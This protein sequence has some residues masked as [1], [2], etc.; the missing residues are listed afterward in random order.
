MRRVDFVALALVIALSALLLAWTWVLSPAKMPP[1]PERHAYW[2]FT[3][4][5][6]VRDR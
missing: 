1:T 4:E 2:P 5:M 3:V 6:S